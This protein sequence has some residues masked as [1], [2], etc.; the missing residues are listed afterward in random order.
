MLKFGSIK[1]AEIKSR[2]KYSV[3]ALYV[4]SVFNC[5]NVYSISIIFLYDEM[6]PSLAKT[7]PQL[8]R[9]NVGVQSESATLSSLLISLPLK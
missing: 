9:T 2:G 4:C 8:G 1:N 5:I 7:S 6:Y 3:N